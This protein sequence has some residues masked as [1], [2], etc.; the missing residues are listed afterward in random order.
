MSIAFYRDVV[1]VPV[2][3]AALANGMTARGQQW[4]ESQRGERA[5]RA[6]IQ[7]W[8]VHVGNSAI[9]VRPRWQSVRFGLNVARYMVNFRMRLSDHDAAT[10]VQI[11]AVPSTM[12]YVRLIVWVLFVAIVVVWV[13]ANGGPPALLGQF[14]LTAA[15]MLAAATVFVAVATRTA[16]GAILEFVEEAGGLAEADDAR[17]RH[18][19]A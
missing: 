1:V 6:G 7:T 3:A 11:E 2:Q 18:E 19:H 10:K 13:G 17:K 12:Y 4:E 15:L 16:R 14:V 8:T 9:L 5:R